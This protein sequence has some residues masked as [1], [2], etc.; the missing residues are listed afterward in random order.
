MS[1]EQLIANFYNSFAAGDAEGMV[2]NYADDIAFKDP[3]FGLLKGNEAK[4]MWRMLLKN[5]ELKVTADNIKADNNTGSASWVAVYKFS[6]TGRTIINKVSAKFEFKD[7][8]II[9]HT[10]Y[11]SFWKWGAQAFG[12]KGYLLGWTPIMKNKVRQQALARLK[13]FNNK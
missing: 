13:K 5:A 7:G 3:A 2:I 8:K 6:L 11:F 10:D 12:L 1:N 9:K 4:N